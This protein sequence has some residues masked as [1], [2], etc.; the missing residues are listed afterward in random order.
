VCTPTYWDGVGEVAERL[1]C[2]ADEPDLDIDTPARA[3]G[4]NGTTPPI[5]DARKS[6]TARSRQ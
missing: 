5:P 4:C 2:R 1:L 3:F 6:S